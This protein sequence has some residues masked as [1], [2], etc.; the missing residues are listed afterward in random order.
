MNMAEPLCPD[1][2]SVPA[3]SHAPDAGPGMQWLLAVNLIAAW[4]GAGGV[5]RQTLVAHRLIELVD[6]GGT[7]AVERAALG[8][9]DVAGT[10]LELYAASVGVPPGDVLQEVATLRCDKSLWG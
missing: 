8:L 2:P 9:A 7:A 1:P 6:E 5:H 10:L 4:R 3:E